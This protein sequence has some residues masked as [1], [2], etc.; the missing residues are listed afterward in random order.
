M[1]RREEDAVRRAEFHQRTQVHHRHAI[2]YVA[3]HRQIVGDEQQRQAQR[4]LEL[5]EQV[6]HLRLHRHVQ[7]R[8]GFV[9]D[10]ELRFQHQC[11]GDADALPLPAGELVRI[12]R[13]VVRV[14]PHPAQ[15]LADLLADVRS[16]QA[17]VQ[18]QPLADDLADGHARV[19]GR[20][21]VL[22][23]H[24]HPAR[25]AL[26]VPGLVLRRQ[27]FAIVDH[28]AAGLVVQAEHRL[29][30]RGLARAA[31]AHQPDDL[32]AGDV[33]GDVVH[34]MHHLAAADAEVLGQV[35]D[36]DQRVAHRRYTSPGSRAQSSWCSQQRASWPASRANASGGLRS[37]ARM[38]CGQRAK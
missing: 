12:A 13:H 30:E 8:D 38:A 6:H 9:A 21:R 29:A 26:E 16:G 34:G 5:V 25:V 37:Q 4:L 31:F 36:F 1:L 28:F 3:H 35:A 27:R 24:L 19:Q 7:R 33:E 20:V 14:Q 18:L 11:P 15:P 10:H 23:D 32:A 2:G 22:E 17:A